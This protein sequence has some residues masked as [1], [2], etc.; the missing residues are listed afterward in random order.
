MLHHGNLLVPYE[1]VIVYGAINGEGT[2]KRRK[3]AWSDEGEKNGA[4]GTVEMLGRER[5][6]IHQGRYR[7][8]YSIQ[9]KQR[10]VSA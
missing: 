4:D 8:V 6:P 10:T 9:D 7:I 3:G 1:I 2:D 5:Y